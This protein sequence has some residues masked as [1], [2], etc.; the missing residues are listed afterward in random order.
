[1]IDF[2]KVSFLVLELR[3]Y[4]TFK[5]DNKLTDAHFSTVFAQFLFIFCIDIYEKKWLCKISIK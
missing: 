4:V 3:F 5:A 1:M 2:S